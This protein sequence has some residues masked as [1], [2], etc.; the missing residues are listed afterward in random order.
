MIWFYNVDLVSSYIFVCLHA[1]EALF[2][3]LSKLYHTIPFLILKTN[4]YFIYLYYQVQLFN[5]SPFSER[6]LY[7]RRQWVLCVNDGSMILLPFQFCSP[8]YYFKIFSLSELW[9]L[10]SNL[11]KIS[12]IPLQNSSTSPFIVLVLPFNFQPKIICLDACFQLF[13]F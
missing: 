6:P 8:W 4:P 2:L 3:S 10:F 13:S 5:F 7:V 12:K 11:P 9:N 1:A